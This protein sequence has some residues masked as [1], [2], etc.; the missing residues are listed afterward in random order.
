[1]AIDYAQKPDSF[2]NSDASDASP[3]LAPPSVQPPGSR[4]QLSFST[5]Y[6]I[7][8]ATLTRTSPVRARRR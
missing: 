4:P 2:L 7:R 3:L 6:Q 5:E 8:S 1:M